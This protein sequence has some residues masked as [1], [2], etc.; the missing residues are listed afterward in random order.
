MER[1]KGIEPSSSAWKAVAL[2]L[3]YT[4]FRNRHH[5]RP[6]DRNQLS[7][8]GGSPPLMGDVRSLM[9]GEVGLEPTKAYASGF[10]VR[11]LCHSGHS[12]SVSSRVL[13]VRDLKTKRT[14]RRGRGSVAR[15]MGMRP[16]S[17]NACDRRLSVDRRDRIN[18]PCHAPIPVS[19]APAPID[20][21]ASAFH[22]ALPQSDGRRRYGSTVFIRCWRHSPI[23]AARSGASSPHPTPS[24]ESPPPVPDC[25]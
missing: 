2:P 23:R 9:V 24:P 12:P 25:R 6:K 16:F 13:T 3:S 22:P 20:A 4:R 10:T 5:Y 7:R 19:R 14:P 15:F 8:A 17:V 18:Q 21:V 1:V 11:P